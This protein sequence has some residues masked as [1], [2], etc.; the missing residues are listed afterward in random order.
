M[1]MN[2]EFCSFL[3]LEGY[4]INTRRGYAKKNSGPFEFFH[5]LTSSYEPGYQGY[6]FGIAVQSPFHK[7]AHLLVSHCIFENEFYY[8]GQKTDLWRKSEFTSLSEKIHKISIPWIE[9]MKDLKSFVS[10]FQ[11]RIDEGLAYI[12][13]PQE[14]RACASLDGAG[15]EIL[16]LMG[17]PGDKINHEFVGR[18][19]LDVALAHDELKDRSAALLSIEKYIKFLEKQSYGREI[20]ENIEGA[21]EAGSWPKSI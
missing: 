4:R 18:F 14:K 20:I 3:K 8:G 19:N 15:S 2:S 17:G 6:E 1:D 9:E 13:P 16:E 7:H 21:I 12:E 5:R 10:H 11:W